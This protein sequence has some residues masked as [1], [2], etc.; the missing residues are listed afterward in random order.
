M[1]VDTTHHEY[2]AAHPDWSIV[3]D[4]MAGSRAVKEAGTTY[5]PRLSGDSDDEYRAYKMRAK[6]FNATARTHSSLAGFIFR[7]D[8]QFKVP[9]EMGGFMADATMTGLSFLEYCKEVARDVLS[10]GRIG[11]L[12]DFDGDTE[13]RPYVCAYKAE[14]ILNWKLERIKGRVVL[15]M[16]TLFE[17]DAEYY[18]SIDGQKKA[19]D[20]YEQPQFQ[21]WRVYRLE[22]DSEGNEFVTCTIYRKKENDKKRGPEFVAIAKTVPTR[23][24][25]ALSAIPFIFHNAENGLPCIGKIPLLDMAEINLAHY[26]TSADLENGRHFTGLPTPWAA[27]FDA[28]DDELKIGSNTAWVTENS[29][30]KVGYLEFTGQGLGA[31]KEAIE[32]HERQMAALGAKMLEPESKKAEAFDTVAARQAAESSALTNATITCTETLSDVMQ[33]VDWWL[34]TADSP[35]DLED[36]VNVELN[37]EFVSASISSDLLRELTAAYLGGAIDFP[38]YCYKLQQGEIIPPGRSME[39][40]RADIESHPPMMATPPDAVPA[41]G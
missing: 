18:P 1:P 19:P 32:E 21:Q 22:L 25:K 5:L 27:G 30:A 10:V 41:N 4:V 31:L 2:D 14:N 6:F 17:Y 33:L 40:I 20:E 36:T 34:G 39:E 23:R 8:P 3:R 16:L 7:K 37:T 26:R 29:D 11:T 15:T 12:V 24:G 35:E 38:T 13:N 28:D 9:D